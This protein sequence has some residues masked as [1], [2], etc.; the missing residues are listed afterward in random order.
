MPIVWSLDPLL[1]HAL[2]AKVILSDIGLIQGMPLICLLLSVS[3][4]LIHKI[5]LRFF[6]SYADITPASKQIVVLHHAVEAIVLSFLFPIF[7]AYMIKVNFQIHE[8]DVI[9][10]DY[11]KIVYFSFTAL[12]MYML[13]LASRVEKPRVIIIVHH[14]LAC[15]DGIMVFWLPTSVMSKTSTVLIYFVF[16]EALTFVGLFMYRIFPEKK[17]TCHVILIGMLFFGISRPI[18]V[19]WVGV[20]AI[21]SW[22][23]GNDEKWQIVFQGTVTL[24]LSILQLKTLLI[25]YGIWKRLSSPAKKTNTKD[26]FKTQD[27]S[28][29]ESS[30]AAQEE[31]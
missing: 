6:K 3:Y 27:M 21:S 13:E 20:I 12:F 18:Q 14:L 8:F 1:H 28:L 11:K 30:E 24:I 16:F 2:P 26:S 7:T 29:D 10:A 31:V 19:L 22:K 15:G 9:M 5:L 23:N 4:P 17:V 25:H